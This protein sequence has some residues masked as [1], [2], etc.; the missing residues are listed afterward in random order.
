MLTRRVLLL[1]KGKMQEFAGA[2]K[3][4]GREGRKTTSRNTESWLSENEEG[5]GFKQGNN[6]CKDLELRG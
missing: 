4:T 1:Q 2:K 5:E 3:L 6:M